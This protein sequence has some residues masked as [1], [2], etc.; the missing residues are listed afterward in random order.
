MSG[1]FFDASGKF[2]QCGAVATTRR[3]PDGA[4]SAAWTVDLSAL[5]QDS[6]QER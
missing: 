1:K 5:A 3:R 6:N 2:P 4:N